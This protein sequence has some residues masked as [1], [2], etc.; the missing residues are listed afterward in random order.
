MKETLHKRSL[1]E[2]DPD[3]VLCYEIDVAEPLRY[4]GCGIRAPV[5]EPFVQKRRVMPEYV[6]FLMV[7]GEIF[8]TDEMPNGPERVR[9]G[10]GELHVVAPGLYQASTV[11]FAP[12]IVF[13]WFHFWCP[14]KLR[15]LTRAQTEERVRTYYQSWEKRHLRQHWL[16]PRHLALGRKLDLFTQAHADLLKS[17]RLW[18]SKDPGTAV[19]CRYLVYQLHLEFLDQ[20]LAAPQAGRDAPAETHANRALTFIRL[21]YDKPITPADVANEL[22][23]NKAYLSRCFRRATGE[24]LGACL[25]RTRLSAAKGLLREGQYSVKE[26]AHLSGF[27]SSGYF[28]RMFR[29]ATGRTPLAFA[30]SAG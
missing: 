19:L 20:V 26:I 18:G 6:A 17:R 4:R 27:G 25:L 5:D 11:P 13:L 15:L 9:V 8:L 2:A 1:A 16:V 28:C 10:P 23:L 24:T 21:Q 14:G 12:G 29:R 7:R 22:G 3:S 30:R